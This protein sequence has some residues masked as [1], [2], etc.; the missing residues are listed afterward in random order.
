MA[1]EAAARMAAE[2]AARMAAVAAVVS[3]C[4]PTLKLLSE[5]PLAVVVLVKAAVAVRT[6][7]PKER[8]AAVVTMAT[9]AAT[10]NIRVTL[11]GLSK[12]MA[13]Q[14]SDSSFFTHPSVL[15]VTHRTRRLM[16]SSHRPR[17][18]S[19]DSPHTPC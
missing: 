18:L 15:D 17:C 8:T 12:T 4:M 6:L 7:F 9:M 5:V 3:I 11:S 14:A 1:A 19:R 10:S 2:A 13:P 16:Q